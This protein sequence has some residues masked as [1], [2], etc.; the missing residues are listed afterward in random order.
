MEVDEDGT[1]MSA[2]TAE[3]NTADAIDLSESEDEEEL[4]DLI[5]EFDITSLQLEDACF[6]LPLRT[7]SRLT[8]LS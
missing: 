3:V 5:E 8:T 1:P 6:F 4:E 7:I 2:E